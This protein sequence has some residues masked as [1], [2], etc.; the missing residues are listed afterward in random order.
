MDI[1]RTKINRLNG[2]IDVSTVPGGG[3]KFTIR[4][5]LTLAI[6]RCMLFGLPHGV[7]AVP[8]ENI[9]GIVAVGESQIVAVNGRHSCDIRGEFLPLVDIHDVFRWAEGE[10]RLPLAG[11]VAV[12]HAAGRSIG[13]R[14][15]TLLGS[16]DIVVKSL[17]DNFRHVRGLGGA[18]ILG[19][20]KVCLL[21]DVAT[22]IE[23]VSG[24]RTKMPLAS[25]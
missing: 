9:R 6:V 3:T 22:A 17:D 12:L 14:V 1:V 15:G 5:P 8:M 19:D 20:G 2:S 7:F 25:P 23:L 16:Q 24:R 11:D 13:L 18:S 4:L 10:A 21:L